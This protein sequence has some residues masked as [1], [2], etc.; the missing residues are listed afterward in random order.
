MYSWKLLEA[1]SSICNVITIMLDSGD[2]D[3][4]LAV[5]RYGKGLYPPQVTSPLPVELT[6]FSVL[7]RKEK[8]NF[9][10]TRIRAK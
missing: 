3:G 2:N 8:F 9:V 10:K 6:S 1:L 5:A 7:F 4:I